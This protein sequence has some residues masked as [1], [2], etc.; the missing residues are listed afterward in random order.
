MIAQPEAS[1]APA[2][3]AGRRL[4]TSDATSDATPTTD[5]KR[6]VVTAASVASASA[7]VAIPA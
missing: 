6:T 7:R 3:H 4:P 1:S 2:S 5:M